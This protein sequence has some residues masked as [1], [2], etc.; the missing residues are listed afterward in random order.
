M[1]HLLSPKLKLS[2][3]ALV[4]TL[5]SVVQAANDDI[6]QEFDVS[7]GGTLVIDSD[8]GAIKVESW[9]RD[10]VLVRVMNTDGFEV[11]VEQVGDSISVTAESEGRGFFGSRRSN[12][13][14]RV[15][16]P[17]QY[18]VELDTGGG[19]I[20]VAELSGNVT[21]DTSG[22]S[23][24]IGKINGGDVK[25]DTSGGSIDI[26][27]VDGNVEVDTAGGRITIGN[28]TGDVIADTSGGGISIGNVQGDMYA[29]TS[30]GNIDVGQG[31]GRVELDTSGGTIRAAWAIGAIIADTSGGNIILEGSATSVRADTSGGNIT[32]EK[33]NGPVDADT[34]GGSITIRK[35]VGPIRADTNGGRID[36]ELVL[37]D[38]PRAGG[39]EL[40]TA[41][42]DV[43]VRIPSSMQ[44]SIY[45]DLEVSR[46][47]R[48][49]Y[50]I[51]TDFPL[52]IQE[53]DRGNIV[54][55]GDINGGGSRI[56]LETTNSDINI[57][58]VK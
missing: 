9:E 39:V 32:V 36:A 30:G 6:E 17:K 53:D 4:F 28:V 46:R 25:A 3:I 2:A 40:E 33:S 16:V 8:V 52:T 24:Q 50:R 38:N 55:Q 20:D 5:S 31:A 12:I 21:V 15:S 11:K 7:S 57:L 56:Y 27:D 34:S 54:G 43:T 49:D 44:A 45:A 19:P 51:Y 58:S 37:S 18:N 13:S 29:N 35:S 42:G 41:G 14:F 1:S 10:Q 22:G 48:G 23:I 26:E 47:G